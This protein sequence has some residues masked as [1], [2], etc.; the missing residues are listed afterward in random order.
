MRKVLYMMGILD[1]S[2]VAWIAANGRDQLVAPPAVLIRE[3]EPVESVYILLEGEL[4]VTA[5][6]LPVTSLFSGEIVGEISLVDARLPLATITARQTSRV[7]AV[8]RQV[9]KRKLANDPQFASRFYQ[10]MAT[11]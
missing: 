8:P 10:A 9:L 3:G 5:G 11:F 1:D 2:D 7:L 4:A 6:G